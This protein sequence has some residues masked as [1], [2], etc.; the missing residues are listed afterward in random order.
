MSNSTHKFVSAWVALLALV[1]QLQVAPVL[2][3][4]DTAA[5][6]VKP[7]P[8]SNFERFRKQSDSWKILGDP[9]VKKKI[10]AAMGTAAEHY[11][12]CTQLVS[13]PQVSGDDVLITAGVRGLFTIAESFL[14][15]NVKTCSLIVGYLGDKK[16]HVYGTTNIDT[17]PKPLQDYIK[18]LEGENSV[19]YDKP[20]TTPVAVTA[21]TPSPKKET[22]NLATV[23]GTYERLGGDR[24]NQGSIDVLVLPKGKIKFDLEAGDGGHTGSAQGEAPLVNNSATYEQDGGKLKMQFSGKYLTISGDDQPFCGMGVTLLGKYQKTKDASPKFS[25]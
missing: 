22:L 23:T 4:T 13:D 20:S 25:F 10:K 1:S 5:V 16:Y 8:T 2:A 3:G 9:E 24:F 6:P 12:D 17:A 7:S 15:L 19:V 14:N 21:T 18:K 11:Y